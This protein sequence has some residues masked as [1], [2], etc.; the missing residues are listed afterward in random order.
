MSFLKQFGRVVLAGSKLAIGLSPLIPTS[1]SKEEKVKDTIENIAGV[2]LTTEALGASLNTL[3]VAKLNA[4][5]PIVAQLLM[6]CD[7]IKGKKIKDQTLFLE[8]SKAVADGMAKILNS[9]HEDSLT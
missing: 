5:A 3:G 6:Q 2:I 8:G 7:L 9:L 1:T 4:S